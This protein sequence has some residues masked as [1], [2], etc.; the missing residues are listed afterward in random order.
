MFAPLACLKEVAEESVEVVTSIYKY[1][2][3]KTKD[4]Y[5]KTS[6]RLKGQVSIPLQQKT[7]GAMA[8]Q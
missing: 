3:R 1:K 8:I 6:Q 5:S 7:V 2:K 4:K